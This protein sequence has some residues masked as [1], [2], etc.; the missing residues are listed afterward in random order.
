MKLGSRLAICAAATAATLT[1]ANVP[2]ARAATEDADTVPTAPVLAGTPP[3]K[4]A[5]A[6]PAR[7]NIRWAPDVTSAQ[8]NAITKSH[9]LRS[10]KFVDGDPRRRTYSY[11]VTNPSAKNLLDL[12]KNPAVEDTH[13]INRKTGDL[14]A[15]ADG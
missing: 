4:L 5:Q 12:V 3:M 14:I 7:I 15:D 11:V 8:R 10:A 2:T 13:G 6:N 9:G 1:I